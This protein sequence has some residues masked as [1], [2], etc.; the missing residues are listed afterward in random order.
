MNVIQATALTGHNKCEYVQFIA[1]QWQS[2]QTKYS[3]VLLLL[4]GDLISFPRF[5]F[6]FFFAL[7]YC[8]YGIAFTYKA[9]FLL[10]L[11]FQSVFKFFNSSKNNQ[12]T[13][14]KKNI[15]TFRIFL[16]TWSLLCNAINA[17]NNNKSEESEL[18]KKKNQRKN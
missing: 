15:S 8:Y 10:L 14:E 5:F 2:V 3:C 9:T 7:F 11:S 1:M 12:R 18:K 6:F 16:A 4:L 13:R 17:T